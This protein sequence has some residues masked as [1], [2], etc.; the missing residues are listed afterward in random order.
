MPQEKGMIFRDGIG[1]IFAFQ[2]R[3]RRSKRGAVVL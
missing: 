2:K 1:W 3:L